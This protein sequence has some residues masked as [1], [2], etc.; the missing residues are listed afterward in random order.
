MP[1][2]TILL[3]L[4]AASSAPAAPDGTVLGESACP[5]L[6]PHAQLDEFGRNF[7]DASSWEAVRTNGVACR[8][9]LYASGGAEVEAFVSTPPG[10]ATGRKPAIIWNRGGTGD[11]GRVDAPLLAEMRLLA[12]QG[13]V[14]AGS[15]YRF[16]GERARRDEWGGSDL[17]DVMNLVPLLKARPDVDARNLFIMGLSR[18]GVMTYLALRRGIPVN[19]A[20]VIAG[21]TDLARLVAER[22]EFLLGY[23]EY[24]G[25]AK[26]WPDFAKRS[27]EHFEAR[28]PVEWPAELRKPVLIL[29]SRTDPRV[30]AGHAL[31][32][33]EKLQEAGAEYELVVYG[34]D[35]HGLARNRADRNRR[36]VEWF[37]AHAV[38]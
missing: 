38:E 34:R 21:P 20:A 15:N 33:A 6:P 3:L 30:S 10:T 9:V 17:D 18:G 27:Q 14:V 13:F 35:G 28:S 23:D 19:A 37:R 36:I 7:F 5:E 1:L 29:H 32:L 16:V 22:P 12:A 31:A 26:V 8:R 2:L 11:Y 4:A 24:D 25:W